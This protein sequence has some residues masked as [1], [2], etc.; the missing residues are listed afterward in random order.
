MQ[1]INRLRLPSRS[2]LPGVAIALALAAAASF[3]YW[4]LR[5]LDLVIAGG[6]V[7]DG[8]GASPFRADVAVRGGKIAGISRWLYRLAPART[9]INA[10]GKVVAPGFID[11]HAHIEA[12]LPQSG[13]F[14]PANFLKQGVTTMVTGNCGRS[15][16]DVAAMLSALEKH[17]TYINVATLIGHNSV[18]RQVMGQE[19]RAAS[20][21]ELQRMK[22]VVA[23]GM[24]EGAFGFSTGLAYTPGRFATLDE[25][26]ALARVAA[27]RGGIYAS[28]IRNEA[29]GGEEAIREALAVG[30]QSGAVVQ[31]SHL[32]C[33]GQG[34]WGSM[35]R[36]LNLLDEARASGLRVFTDAYP[37]ERSSTTTDILLPDW[38]VA[39]KR[40]GVKLAAG[41]Q[42]ARQRLRQDILN[43]LRADGWQELRHVR[44]VAGR[45]EWIGRTLAEVP[46]PAGTLDGQIENLIEVSL[47]GGAQAIYA[48][49]N[50]ADVAE[51]LSNPFCVFGSDSAVRDPEGDYKPHPRGSGTFPRIFKLYV[52][53]TGKLELSQAVHKASGL[54][55]AILGLEGRGFLSTGA[56]AD[57][58][59]FDL[60]AIEDRS[61]YD[62]P[63]AEPVGIEYVI[64]NGSVAVDHGMLADNPPTGAALRPATKNSAKMAE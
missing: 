45:P 57:I 49:M 25:L 9:R 13:E 17:G 23:R 48:D 2:V 27:E 43:K 3:I 50:E 4:R 41:N 44:L 42:A 11:V 60:S 10:H 26:T 21:N 58:V 34:Q 28:H 61:D 47:R 55:A 32:K 52:R 12:N 1:I 63:F 15:R 35:S 22:Q 40:A 51:A 20:P 6:L 31:I 39:N 29:S 19:A 62:Q 36:R 46:V 64:V 24:E 30:K 33:S 7:V 16:T 14:R 8:T 59:I 56:W 18:R 53:E 38:A 37:Y 5:D 54:P